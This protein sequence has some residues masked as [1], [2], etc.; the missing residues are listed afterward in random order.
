MKRDHGG[1]AAASIDASVNVNPLGPPESLDPVFARARDLAG[2]YPEID[3]CSAREAWA[4]RLGLDTDRVL[5]GNGASELISLTVRALSPRRVVVFDPC[6]SEYAAGASAA[7]V[8]VAHAPLDLED[9][10]WG[11]PVAELLERGVEGVPLGPG[12]LV[13]IG[14][15]NNPTGHLTSNEAL[16]DIA[17][18]GAHVFADESFLALSAHDHLSLVRHVGAGITVVTSLTKTFSVPGLRLG[19]LAGSPSLVSRIGELRDPWSVNGIAAEA[20]V[21]LAGDSRYLETSRAILAEQRARMVSAVSAIAGMRV[22]EGVAPWLLVELPAPWTAARFR[23]ALLDQG[24]AVRDASTFPGLTDRWVR[25]GVRS[26]AEN[27][28]ILAAIVEAL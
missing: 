22:A 3:A 16:I 24:V 11:T 8:P 7:G 14:V 15:P 18:T 19:V 9:G 4:A 6:Y 27:D 20:A 21:T 26:P 12:D 2:R 13:V 10:R 1:V 28:R 23:S 25:I 5:V 17:S